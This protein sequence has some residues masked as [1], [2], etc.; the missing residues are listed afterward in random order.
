MRPMNNTALLILL[1]FAAKI[2]LIPD[3]EIIDPRGKVNIV[4][5]QNCLSLG[6]LHN[7]PLVPVS[8]FII[9]KNFNNPAF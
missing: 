7:K 4:R 5:D 1:V 8:L 2:N 9:R 6:Q 3:I